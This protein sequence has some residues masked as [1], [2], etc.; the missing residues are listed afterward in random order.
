M[1]KRGRFIW[2]TTMLMA[3][4]VGLVGGTVEA[5]DRRS[6]PFTLVYGGALAKTRRAR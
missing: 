3:T 2:G 6:N 5:A 4:T 1:Q